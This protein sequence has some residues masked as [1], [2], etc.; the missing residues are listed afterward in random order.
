MKIA[1][2]QSNYIELNGK[3]I[4][5]RGFIHWTAGIHFDEVNKKK[6][7]IILNFMNELSAMKKI[8]S[9]T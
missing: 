9:D 8:H 7:D 6:A 1:L 2:P 5:C 3:I 4:W